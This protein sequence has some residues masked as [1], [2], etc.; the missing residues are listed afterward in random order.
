M[1]EYSRLLVAFSSSGEQSSTHSIYCKAHV[2]RQNSKVTP[3]LRTLFSLGWPPYCYP[4]DVESLFSRVGD[5]EKV[6]LQ[7]NPGSVDTAEMKRD[8]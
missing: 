3:N 2:V 1:E 8:S 4:E 7:E 6:Y 5:V